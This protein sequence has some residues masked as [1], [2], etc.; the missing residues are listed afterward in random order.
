MSNVRLGLFAVGLLLPHMGCTSKSKGE[1]TR[2]APVEVQVVTVSQRDVPIYQEWI[3]TL[4]GLVNAD[5]KAEVSGYLTEQSYKEGTFVSK[6]QLLFQIDPRPFQATLDQAQGQ[7]SQ[8]KGGLEQAQ[9][10]LSQTQAQVAIAN[11][12]QGRTQ[13]DV[14]RY[15]P[16]AEQQAVSQ[17]ELDNA[18]QNNLAAQAQ[19]VQA[20]AQVETAKAQITAAAAAVESANATV[21]TARINLGFTR[22]ISPIDGL[23]GIAQLQVG[24]LVS[25]ASGPITTVSTV[26][27]IKVY[28]TVSE[29]EYLDFAR[30]FPTAEQRQSDLRDRVIELILADGIPHPYKGRFDFADRQ[31]DVRTGAIRVAALFPNPGNSLRP[32]QY[33]KV[34][35]STTTEKNAVLVPQRAINELQGIRQVA[36]V[37]PDNKVRIQAVTL[38]PT[39]D[40]QWI[41]REG[42]K[43]GE[44]VIVEGIQK[45]RSGVL[46][47]PK[48]FDTK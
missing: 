5:I 9:A 39:V 37:E 13:L 24:S 2:A 25:P 47:D 48:P 44:R 32:G 28:F 26:D 34:R 40:N 27:P 10:Q 3:G 1:A 46:V 23:P 31:V 16:L 33:G 41:V 7:L 6:G 20:R 19:V 29:Q 12:N 36:I 17:Q 43:P 11:A 15:R 22:I 30:R 42:I 45:V 4:D 35:L 38:G 18:T 21:E 14:E 8:A